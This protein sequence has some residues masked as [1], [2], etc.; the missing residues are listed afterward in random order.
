MEGLKVIPQ[1]FFDLIARVIPGAAGIIAYL[2]LFNKTW[3]QLVLRFL[4][5][6][7][8]QKPNAILSI[9]IFLGAAYFVGQLISPAAKC[10]QRLSELKVFETKKKEDGSQKGSEKSSDKSEYDY[11]RFHHPDVG[12]LCAKIRAEFTMHNGLAVVFV[13]STVYYPFSELSMNWYIFI[14]LIILTISQAIRGKTTRETYNETVLKFNNIA[15][16]EKAKDDSDLKV[17]K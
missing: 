15:K 10:V 16:M 3:E 14:T 11:L 4:G 1:V 9:F 13:L 7:T 5:Q 2:M 8:A 6:E 12:A 17:E